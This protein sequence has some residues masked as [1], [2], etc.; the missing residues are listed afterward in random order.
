MDYKVKR[1][2]RPP[3][4]EDDLQMLWKLNMKTTSNE[5]QPQNWK[6]EYQ[7]N[8]W[9]DITQIWNLGLWDQ[10]K[11]YGNSKWRQTPMKDELENEK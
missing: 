1:N 11:C 2:V 9:S 6:V 5:R 7:S 8:Y 4:M 10:A 3:P